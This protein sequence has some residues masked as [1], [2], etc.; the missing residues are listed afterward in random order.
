[1]PAFLGWRRRRGREDRHR[2][3]ERMGVAGLPR[4]EGRLVWVHAASTGDGQILLPLVGRL[5]ARGFHVLVSTR[6]LASA[7]VLKRMLPA[8]AFHQFMPLDVPAYVTRFLDHWRP[9]MVLLAGAELWPNVLIEADRRDLPIIFVNARMSDRV[10]GYCRRLRGLV[11]TLLGHVDLCLARTELDA[12]RFSDLGAVSVQTVG[13]LVY[14]VP[15]PAADPQVVSALASRIG[16]RPVWVAAMT[17]TGEQGLVVEVHRKLLPRFPDLVTI[18]APRLPRDGEVLARA[19]S[20]QNLATALRSRDGLPAKL[21]GLFV[22]DVAGEIGLF[23][24]ASGIAFLGRSMSGGGRSPIE[25]AKLGCAVLHGPETED[26]AAIYDALDQAQGAAEV[27][28]VETLARVLALLFED[29]GKLRLMQR[30]ALQT[31]DRLCGGTTRVLRAIE[32]HVVQML[33]E[34]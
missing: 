14:D 13:D 20:A 7:N 25:A 18:V 26:Y 12:E 30:N 3:R 34:R 23:Y 28:D 10:Y 24:R 32:P 5:G 33:V 27:G 4:P 1:M 6:T 16:S 22:A 21:P 11:V 9:D 17:E 2:V 8:G 29:G 15:M 31:M 19:A